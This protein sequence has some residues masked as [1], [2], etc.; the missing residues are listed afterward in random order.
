MS[1]AAAAI[2]AAEAIVR[3]AISIVE[4]VDRS[5]A[6]DLEE[7][8][9]RLAALR[10]RAEELPVRSGAGGDYDRRAAQRLAEIEAAKSPDSPEG[11]DPS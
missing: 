8:R 5:L 11:S 6:A 1:P 4:S 10:V 2:A 9:Q 3:V 7:Q